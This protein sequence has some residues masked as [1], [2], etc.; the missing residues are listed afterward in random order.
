M[1]WR[2]L[3]EIRKI[4][5]CGLVEGKY[6]AIPLVVNVKSLILKIA[7]FLPQKCPVQIGKY[8]GYNLSIS[9]NFGLDEAKF[10][11]PQLPNGVYRTSYKF[12]DEDDDK[13]GATFSFNLEV[14]DVDNAEN[15]MK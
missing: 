13:E 11:T 1:Y 6:N 3:Y 15:I 5:Y 7:P 12:Y 2:H 9:N 10:L 4:D 8:Y 14:D